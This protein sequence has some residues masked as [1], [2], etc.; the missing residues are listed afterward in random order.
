MQDHLDPP[1]ISTVPVIEAAA[2][3]EERLIKIVDI[4][5][6]RYAHFREGTS[7]REHARALHHRRTTIR[8]ALEDSGT[9]FVSARHAPLPSGASW[10]WT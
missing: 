2:A 6:I 3:L 7:I 9:E 5:R 1:A 10:S 4:E 8:R